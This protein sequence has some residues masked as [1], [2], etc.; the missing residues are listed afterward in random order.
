M[1]GYPIFLWLLLLA[2][3][4]GPLGASQ[5]PARS[6]LAVDISSGKILAE[7]NPDVARPIASLTKLMTALV[8][9]DQTWPSNCEATIDEQDTDWLKHSS[10]ALPYGY[11][12]T[13]QNLFRIMLFHSENRAAKALARTIFPSER[14]CVAAM[15]AK[16][17]ALGMRHTRFVDPTGLSPSNI[18][19]ARDMMRL[20][21][22]AGR[23]RTIA[24]S[25]LVREDFISLP[26]DDGIK[27]IRNT[28]KLIRE[29]KV[30]AVISKTGF[31]SEAGRSLALIAPRGNR[32]VG[33]VVLGS[34]STAARESVALRVLSLEPKRGTKRRHRSR[35]R[36]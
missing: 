2:S 27:K 17:R 29:G 14:A 33:I 18:S 32:M 8:L 21:K 26:G 3:W 35:G 12:D 34:P 19:S 25:S 5:L 4:S 20:L 10:S 13:C 31:T 11:R 23:N 1:R 6:V 15:N 30:R 24:S 36:A 9:Q 22:E 7:K 28:N 16:A